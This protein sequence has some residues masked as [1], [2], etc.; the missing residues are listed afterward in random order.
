MIARLLRTAASLAIGARDPGYATGR[1]AQGRTLAR[2]RPAARGRLH[3]RRGQQ[4]LVT[5]IEVEQRIGARARRRRRAVRACRRPMS[6]ASRSS[7]TLIEER[8]RPDLLARAAVGST[9]TELDRAVQTIAAQNQLTL[10]ELRRPADVPT[11]STSRAFAATCA[12]R[13]W[14]NARASA[15]CTRASASPT[16]RSKV[17]STSSAAPQPRRPSRNQPRADSRHG[18]EGLR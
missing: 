16:P 5:A 7:T 6:C 2:S 18:A 14:S 1:A 11:G 10:A 17:F 9:T 3:R 13:C 8:V 15:R 4:E 12:T